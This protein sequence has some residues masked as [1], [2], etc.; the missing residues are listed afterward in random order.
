M[1]V[2]R[3]VE[4][5]VGSNAFEKLLIIFIVL[6]YER[7]KNM[8]K[9]VVIKYACNSSKQ[10][11]IKKC[12]QFFFSRILNHV[13]LSLSTEF[14]YCG[15]SLSCYLRTDRPIWFVSLTTHS[16]LY[17]RSE[18]VAKFYSFFFQA[19]KKIRKRIVLVLCRTY[20]YL[21]VD[22]ITAILFYKTVIQTK[23]Y[24]FILVLP[25]HETQNV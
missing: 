3:P 10:N 19:R 9:S 11:R 14:I 20:I 13:F 5:S 18:F 1:C 22:K 23:I 15:A 8:P 6:L 2:L 12:K 17:T 21:M 7:R 4:N 24:G 16:I 25:K